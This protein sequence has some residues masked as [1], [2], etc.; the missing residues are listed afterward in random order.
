M[1]SHAANTNFIVHN[2]QQGD[3]E[4]C[5]RIA[6]SIKLG[7]VAAGAQSPSST[8]SHRASS[9]TMSP[10]TRSNSHQDEINAGHSEVMAWLESIQMGIYGYGEK[11]TEEGFDT[12]SL[13]KELTAEDLAEFGVKKG[14]S[15]VIMRG[16]SGLP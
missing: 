11:F 1:Q 10:S 14:H 4:I 12:I 3:D 16:I 9:S 5:A 7:L 13:L 2:G 15:R 8:P 6:E